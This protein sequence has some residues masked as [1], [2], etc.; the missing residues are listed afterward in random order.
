L[1]R[2]A[3]DNSLKNVQNY[4][5]NKGYTVELLKDNDNLNGYDAIVVSGQKNNFLGIH[6]TVTKAPV[7]NAHGMTPE[8]IHRE[9]E[10]RLR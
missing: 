5:E 3:I 2:I 8:E 7:I 6:D 1:K 10:N 4:L 9:I